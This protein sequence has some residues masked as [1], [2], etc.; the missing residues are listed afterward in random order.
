LGLLPKGLPVSRYQ[1]G[2]EFSH[3]GGQDRPYNVEAG[4]VQ[5]SGV[6]PWSTELRTCGGKG[7]SRLILENWLCFHF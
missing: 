1:A 4:K 2:H 6:K 7:T 5:G 3:P